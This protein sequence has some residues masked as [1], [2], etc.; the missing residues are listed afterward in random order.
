M[1]AQ[2]P[3][4]PHRLVVVSGGT[5]EPS[6]TR[7]LADRILQSTTSR[8]ARAGVELQTTVLEL[9][10][11]AADLAS[12]QVTGFATP[13]LQAAIDRLAVADALVIATPVYKA[14]VSGL[15]KSFVDML[16]TDL[17]IA[18]PTLLAA[19]AG[20]ARH[21]LVADEQLRS[22]FAYLRALATPTSV[23]AASDDWGS[24][25]LTE[26]IDRAANELVVLIE[27]GVRDSMRDTSWKQYQHTFGSAATTDGFSDV[28]FDSDLMSLATGGTGR[29][30]AAEPARSG[31]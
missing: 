8:A 17:L 1:S 9:R 5:S 2:L 22:L 7:M 16:D 19:T 14:G 15:V 28:D 12:A 10:P 26:R 30:T 20:T 4:R 11:L 23:F 27:A 25:S 31:S 3:S 24:K 29:S 18:T 6:S 13:A 21:A